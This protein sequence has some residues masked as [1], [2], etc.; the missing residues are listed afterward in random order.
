MATYGLNLYNSGFRYG[1]SSP[2]S[3]YYNANIK[4]QPYDYGTVR[5]TW[6]TITPV[7]TDPGI[8]A[9]ML[10]KSFSGTVDNPYDGIMIAGASTVTVN[11][12]PY[13]YFPNNYTDT[14][15]GTTDVEASY[16]M[17]VFNGINWIF[18]GSDYAVIVG[19]KETLTTVN[20]WLPRAWTNV[21]SQLGDALGES[22]TNQF[23]Q[24]LSA[25][26]FQYDLFRSEGLILGNVHD[27]T[28]TPSSILKAKMGDY[29]FDYEPALGDTYH[30]TLSSAGYLIQ[31]YKGTPTGINVYTGALTHLTS[32][33]QL[34][35]NL[36]LDYNDSSF[37]E[38]LG[39]WT[40]TLGT[41]TQYAYSASTSTFGVTLSA[42]TPWIYDKLTPPRSA[43]FAALVIPGAPTPVA[44]NL[45]LP[46]TSSATNIINYA[47]PVSPN[48]RYV[49]SAWVRHLGAATANVT[50]T[51]SWYDQNG[52]LI[53]TTAAGAVTATS[54]S[55]WSEVTSKS[56]TGRNGQLSPAK[57]LYAVVDI[58]VLPTTTAATTVFV[59]MVQLANYINSLEFEDARR[60]RVYLKGQRENLLTNPSFE[61]GVGGWVASSNASFAQDP[62]VYNTGLFDGSS[63]GELTVQSGTGAWVSS[64]WFTVTPGQ[65]YTFSAYVS[66]E[67]PTAGR[68]YLLIEYSNR[69]TI[70][71]QTQVLTDSNGQYYS[72]SI[73]SVKSDYA[74]LTATQRFDTSNNPIVDTA[75]PQYSQGTGPGTYNGYPIQYVPVLQR[76]SVSA[77]APDQQKDSGQPLAKVSLVFPDMTGN[78]LTVWMD[79]LMFENAPTVGAYFSGAGAPTP[80]DP[81]TNYFINSSD[82]FW[83]TK[84]LINYIQNPSFESNTNY[85]T[86]AVGTGLTRDAGPAPASIR[87]SNPDGTYQNPPAGI[88]PTTYLPAYGSYMGKVSYP[89]VNIVSISSTGSSVTYIYSGIAQVF[90][91]GQ[92]VAI[93]GNMVGATPKYNNTTPTG[94]AASA[95]TA[96]ATITP[97]TMYSFTV[98]GTDTGTATVFGQAQ[99]NGAS[100]STT[101]YLSS[102]AIGGEDF[103]VHAQVRAAEG[104][105]TI[106][107]SGNGLTTSNNM[108]VYQHDQYQWIRIWNARQLVAGETSFT[109]TIS[110]A[111]PPQFYPTGGPGYTIA[112]TSYFHIDGVQAEYSSSPSGFLNPADIKYPA[113]SM[114]NPGNPST[115]MWVGQ[116]PSIYGGK[117]NYINNY[118][119]KLS[120]LKNT[121]S[122]IMP[123]GSTWAVKPG[124]PTT[125]I[126]DLTTS[127]IPS[128][129]FERD[130]GT[131]SGTSSTL[132][133][134]VSRGSLFG[135]N[136]SH[137]SAYCSVTSTA[138]GTYGITSAHV[139]VV[140]AQGY[141]ASV[142]I[143]P[144]TSSVGTYTLTVNF[145]D[146]NGTLIP[147]LYGTRIVS[148]TITQ[149]NRWAYLANTFSGATTVNASYAVYT[150]TCTPTT[151]STGQSFGVDRC[152]FR[153]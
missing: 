2:S 126:P 151:P 107:T 46:S 58:S 78:G 56:D 93:W 110:I 99:V 44:A 111:L 48:T 121:L 101:V 145:Y 54:N 11:N 13:L 133:R 10:V 43:G 30:R 70:A 65:N 36:M 85:W 31:K 41:L 82:A 71:L 6:G 119:V 103:I 53:S 132:A 114:P 62:T 25:V 115:T 61:N 26:C 67:Y 129:S 64:P 97:G 19:D 104:T 47:I 29:S 77:I 108:E 66:S 98:A 88:V 42:P 116:L 9:W 23:T 148:A 125:T 138:S 34:G 146:A 87:L 18:C 72:P 14:T 137:G 124:Y 57:T 147:A 142:A 37:E 102:P 117:S 105:Y 122:N 79:A 80:S 1:Q 131:W 100:I 136:V 135:D 7:P 112:T 74:T 4:A 39:R 84:N 149:T 8:S 35:T 69:E 92:S 113:I 123:Q 24:F 128:A 86:T 20:R 40:T 150:V 21:S 68:A 16:S 90:A 106:G 27:H 17:W 12:S 134:V 50:A 52:S 83:E 75:V 139:A 91:V 55:A 109:V 45:I 96:I 15:Y 120:R 5:I 140:P 81:T 144:T 38:S 51:I 94:W 59:D 32:K 130:L 28:K 118:A 95:I 22:D 127:L 33:V 76:L 89:A 152:V 143:R 3:L 49:F 63:L 73:Y 141:Y 153:Q 60:V